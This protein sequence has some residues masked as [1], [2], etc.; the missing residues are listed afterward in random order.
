M[1]E[2]IMAGLRESIA[3]QQQLLDMLEGESV[4][5]SKDNYRG[6]DIWY[7]YSAGIG[8]TGH[9][10]LET[11]NRKHSIQISNFHNRVECHQELARMI[12]NLA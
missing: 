4:P 1:I 6:W 9:A 10:Q 12:D 11:E 3:V 2:K 8:F 5:S 7:E